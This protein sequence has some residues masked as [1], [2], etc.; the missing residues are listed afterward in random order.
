MAQ[1]LE[2]G[3]PLAG[4]LRVAGRALAGL[5]RRLRPDQLAAAALS[6][7]GLLA[8]EAAQAG[9]PPAPPAEQPPAADRPARGRR[10]RNKGKR[11]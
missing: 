5:F 10:G 7:P 1:S 6:T 3:A 8:S 9:Q 4:A 11:E 2:S